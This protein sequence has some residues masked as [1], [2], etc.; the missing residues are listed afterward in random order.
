MGCGL[1]LDGLGTPGRL[2]AA[3]FRGLCCAWWLL[4]SSA[5]SFPR[6][7]LLVSHGPE[8]ACSEEGESPGHP[9]QLIT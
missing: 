6:P 9:V 7:S 4:G 1:G 3:S 2:E 8:R 5:F